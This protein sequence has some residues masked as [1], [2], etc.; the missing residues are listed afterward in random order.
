MNLSTFPL[1]PYLPPKRTLQKAKFIMEAEDGTRVEFVAM[2]ET[3]PASRFDPPPPPDFDYDGK[4]RGQ[5]IAQPKPIYFEGNTLG[6]VTF[7][8]P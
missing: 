7:F 4:F 3:R 5:K 2:V 8:L 6:A 1:F